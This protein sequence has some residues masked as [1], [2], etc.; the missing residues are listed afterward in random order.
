M[1][2]DVSSRRLIL[3]AMAGNVMEWYDFLVHGDVAA[4]PGRWFF[5]SEDATV[6]LLAAFGVLVGRDTITRC[7]NPDRAHGDTS[8]LHDR[9]HFC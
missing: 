4:T 9:P 2:G 5:P 6:S 1:H 3:A 7:K 8:G